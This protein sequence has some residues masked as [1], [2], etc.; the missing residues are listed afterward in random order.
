MVL[1]VVFLNWL[2]VVREGKEWKAVKGEVYSMVQDELGILFLKILDYT[3]NGPNLKISVLRLDR[4]IRNEAYFS[5]LCKLKEMTELKLNT[6]ELKLLL[7]DKDLRPF[8]DVVQNLSSLE[9]KY[10]RFLPSEL[11]LAIM[12][13][14]QSIR[15]LEYYSELQIKSE[16]LGPMAKELVSKPLQEMLTTVTPAI[17][18]RVFKSLIEE[19][20]RIH[21]MGI[22]LSPVA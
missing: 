14:Q 15:L 10:S 2:F 13:I 20:H 5:E 7:E 12:K 16:E 19:I 18:S 11:T 22:E 17:T 1:T 6:S 21:K 4:K 8:S 9:L 3:E